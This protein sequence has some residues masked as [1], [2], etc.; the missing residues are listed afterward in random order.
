MPGLCVLVVLT[1]CQ[2]NTFARACEWLPLLEPGNGASI[3]DPVP[4]LHWA[5]DSSVRYR[6]QMAL[7]EPEI[8]PG[9][10]VDLQVQGTRLVWPVAGVK[11]R[12]AVKVL[13]S[14]GCNGYSSAELNAQGPSFVIDPKP[15]C[16][17]DRR[18]IRMTSQGW[19][20]SA[21]AG[22]DTYRLRRIPG[23]AFRWG[24]PLPAG[25]VDVVHEPRWKP[26]PPWVSDQFLIFEAWCNGEPGPA[27]VWSQE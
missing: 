24:R 10:V 20:W 13:I 11:R 21:V 4:S 5:G 12:T 27:V 19:E 9:Q 26:D 14:R 25:S 7:I 15:F 8:G 22:A 2:I 1:A 16:Q 3:T 6:V 23:D 18:S 17:P